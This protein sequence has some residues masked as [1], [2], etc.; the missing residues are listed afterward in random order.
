[1]CLEGVTQVAHSGSHDIDSSYFEFCKRPWILGDCCG[2]WGDGPPLYIWV[3]QITSTAQRGFYGS[4]VGM[5][6][7]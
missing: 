2:L 3:S 6:R 1:M 5:Y 4:S 7:I